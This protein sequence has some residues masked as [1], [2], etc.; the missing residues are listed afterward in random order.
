MM[1]DEITIAFVTSPPVRVAA[2]LARDWPTLPAAALRAILGHLID[3]VEVTG[4]GKGEAR[5]RVVA[6]WGEEYVYEV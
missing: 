1:E 6:A 5:V 3:R 2:E 4:R